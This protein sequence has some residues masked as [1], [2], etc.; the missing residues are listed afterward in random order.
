MPG[1]DAPDII[2]GDVILYGL[3][4]GLSSPV[5]YRAPAVAPEVEE[6]EVDAGAG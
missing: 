2:T 6:G 3:P 4:I 5:P 1:A